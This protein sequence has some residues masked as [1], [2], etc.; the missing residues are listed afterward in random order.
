[1]KHDVTLRAAAGLLT[2]FLP[3]AAQ[4]AAQDKP[5]FTGSWVLESG[6]SGADIPQSLLVSQSVVQTNVPFTS[7]IAI[8]RVLATST[9]SE[10]YLIGV[11]GGTTA[12]TVRGFP[13][14]ANGPQ[15]HFAVRW[16]EQ[17][18]VIERGSYT[19][20]SRETGDWS[21]RREVWSL[22]SSLRLHLSISTRSSVDAATTVTLIY[23]RQ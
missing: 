9:H 6:S 11:V 13:D 1:M 21:E 22:D 20:P 3:F 15:T 10:T 17:S 5:D 8:T 4:T 7:D 18:L 14:R 2:V 16:D 12:G 19:G 23:R